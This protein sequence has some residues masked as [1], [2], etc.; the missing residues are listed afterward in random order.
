MDGADAD[1]QGCEAAAVG[2]GETVDQCFQGPAR[3]SPEP[4]DE[5][6]RDAPR[7]TA[8]VMGVPEPGQGRQGGGDL[9]V[10]PFLDAPGYLVACRRLEQLG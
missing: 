6:E 9:A 1:T 4:F 2:R 10:E 7:R 3:Q 8:E 5:L